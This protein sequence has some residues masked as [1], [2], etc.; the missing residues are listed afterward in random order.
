VE[1]RLTLA[2]ATL[3]EEKAMVEAIVLIVGIV[4]STDGNWY[5]F[6]QWLHLIFS[7]ASLDVLRLF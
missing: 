6:T 7:W 5:R 2:G 3:A 1:V 4:D